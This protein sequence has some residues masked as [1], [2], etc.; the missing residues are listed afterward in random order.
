MIINN[1]CIDILLSCEDLDKSQNSNS[2]SLEF[3]ITKKAG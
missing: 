1:A 3:E 2:N